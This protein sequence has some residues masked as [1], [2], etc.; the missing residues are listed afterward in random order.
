MELPDT[1]EE[2]DMRYL[3][4]KDPKHPANC[5]CMFCVQISHPCGNPRC[6]DPDCL[7]IDWKK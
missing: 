6:T 3:A 7:V 4:S 5:L 2:L 1:W